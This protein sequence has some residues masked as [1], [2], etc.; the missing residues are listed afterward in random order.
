M[1]M[2]YVD[3]VDKLSVSQQVPDNIQT[4]EYKESKVKKARYLERYLSDHWN[5]LLVCEYKQAYS[6]HQKLILG[7]SKVVSEVWL[8]TVR[9]RWTECAWSREALMSQYNPWRNTKSQK[10]PQYSYLLSK[11]KQFYQI[12]K[13]VCAWI[14][15]FMGLT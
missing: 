5:S 2:L 10:R 1:Q 6:E 3:K 7:L 14:F 8:W 9:N 4:M 15:E 13:F 12:Y 11:V